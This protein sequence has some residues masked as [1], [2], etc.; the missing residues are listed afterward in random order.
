M[1]ETF[2]YYLFFGF[3]FSL[4]VDVSTWYYKRQGNELPAGA[5]WDWNT[6]MLAI[7]IWP[8]GV[9]YFIVGFIVEI[10]RKNNKNEK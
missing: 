6:R 2:I 1:L 5:D 9:I 4:V 3:I 8:L 10:T 7:L